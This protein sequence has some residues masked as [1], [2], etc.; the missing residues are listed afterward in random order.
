MRVGSERGVNRVLSKLRASVEDGRYYEAHQMYRTLYF[1]YMTQK[2]YDELLELLYDGILQFF[3]HKQSSS[4]VDLAAL[5][6]DVLVKSDAQITERRLDELARLYELAVPD[7][8]ERAAFL[9]SALKWSASNEQEHRFGHPR[10]HRAVALTLWKEKNYSQS[11]FHFLRSMD[12]ESCASMLVEYH[13]VQG[14]PGE[15]DLFIARAVLQFLCLR[16]TITANVVFFH[17]TQTHPNIN[18]G[19][20]F[21]LPLLNFL[22]FLLLT[23]ES[24][25]LTTFTVLC[26]Q[27]QSSIRRD[28]IY[29]EYLDRIGQLFF[30]LPP[31]RTNRQG[32]LENL[33]QSL[34][35]GPD[36]EEDGSSIADDAE[37]GPARR[38]CCLQPEE[39]D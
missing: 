22:W 30:G 8:P 29:V 5:F 24:G 12:G 15:V 27:Y 36:E 34:L 13:L 18:R 1:R 14:F 7:G 23:I 25:K 4:G 10:L 6:V 38:S 39:L 28:P 2:R 11:W 35:V 26:E 31:P 32:L 20:P 19:P 3:Q 16:N 21:L 9:T 17:Y 37:A 33:L